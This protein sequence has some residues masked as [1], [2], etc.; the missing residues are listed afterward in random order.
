MLTCITASGIPLTLSR[1]T[2][3]YS[4][5]GKHKIIPSLITSCIITGIIASIAIIIII[6][7]AKG[8]MSYLFKDPRAIPIFMIMLPA[9]ISTTLYT[10]LRG[11]FWGIKDFTTFSFGEL[12]EEVFRII[13][14]ILLAG[15]II[16]TL[17]GEIGLALAFTISDVMIAIVMLFIFIKKGGKIGRP[18]EMKQLIKSST[19]ITAMRL[20]SGIISSL[21]AI[22]IPAQL[23]LNGLSPSEATA[24]F[25]RV[26]GLAFPLI[27]I[28]MALTGSIITV[29]IPEIA[30]QNALGNLKGIRTK[31]EKVIILSVAITGLFLGVFIAFGREIGIIIYDDVVAGEFVKVGAWMMLPI[32]INQI[33]SSVLNSLAMEI[34]SFI[35][36]ILGAII[37]L[38]LIYFLPKYIGVYALIAANGVFSIITL[39][40]NVISLKKKGVINL[41]FVKNCIYVIIFAIPSAYIG[42]CIFE[43]IAYTM[44]LIISTSI[45]CIVVLFIYSILIL[46]SNIININY[47]YIG[48]LKN[49]N[50]KHAKT[51][52]LIGKTKDL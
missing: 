44:P 24:A 12:I 39:M 27:V 2:A 8:S 50:E 10:I 26:V 45:A 30:G 36:Y 15:G 20:F 14:T 51:A 13:F 3:E 46:T 42:K 9:L 16:E 32:V 49:N 34:K 25:G 11:W 40:L 47:F 22:I 31:I 35:N 5:N 43:L 21:T 29:L 6:Y 41:D 33:T 17:K 28:P 1:K 19:P 38:F 7:I 48:K 18:K 23:I 37:L 4:M 52:L